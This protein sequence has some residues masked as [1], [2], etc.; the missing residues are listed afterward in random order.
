MF[1]T[2]LLAAALPLIQA[3]RAVYQPKDAE[4]YDNGSYGRIPEEGF[5]TVDLPAYRL[6][7]RTWDEKRC[8]SDD[9]LFLAIRGKR[10]RH[11]GPV[12]YD[13]DGHQVR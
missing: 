13:N 3:D 4:R 8:A 7:H 5:H 12:I 1:F 6:L 2:L 9:K 11:T 10:L